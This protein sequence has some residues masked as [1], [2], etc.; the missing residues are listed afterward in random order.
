MNNK[1][2]I[3]FLK[4]EYEEVFSMLAEKYPKLFKKN[5]PLLLKVGVSQ[6]I[7][8]DMGDKIDKKRL[9]KFFQSYCTE[10]RYVD[11]H[12]AGTPR[13][14]LNGEECGIVSEEH[15][16]LREQ[17]KTNAELR[18]QRREEELVRAAQAKSSKIEKAQHNQAP[19]R[20]TGSKNNRGPIKKRRADE[21][22]SKSNISNSVNA[23]KLKL[24][25]RIR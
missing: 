25:L 18:T 2:E 16:V 22:N 19:K 12:I 9:R 1:K 17:A 11:L 24:G 4:E 20:K 21:G 14:D 23:Q 10:K 3:S 7:L 13:Y 5:S 6:D 8:A 15:V